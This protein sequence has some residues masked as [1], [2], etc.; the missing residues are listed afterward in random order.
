MPVT[1]QIPDSYPVPPFFLTAK[2]DEVAL[3]LELGASAVRHM[4]TK[5]IETVRR[6]THSDITDSYE[7]RIKKLQK[8]Y[9]SERD[10]LVAELERMG[11][12]GAK[13]REAARAE[14]RESMRELIEAKESQ[15]R[16]LE[17]TLQGL[18][19]KFDSLQTS[20]TRT[21]TSSK[22]KG[23][24]GEIIVEGMLKK[25]FDCDVE[26]V[27]KEAQTADIR[28]HR[29]A[30]DVYLWEVKN[31]TRMVTKEEVEKFRRDL[32]LHPEI[33]GGVLVS[34]R[35]GIVGKTRGGDIDVEFLEDGRAILFLSNLLSRDDAVFYLQTLRPFF[36]FVERTAHQ[37]RASCE[38]EKNSVK[39][40]SDSEEQLKQ[41]ALLVGNLIRNHSGNVVKHRNSLATHKKRT[42]AMFVEFQSYLMEAETQ[43]NTVLRLVIAEASDEA[44]LAVAAA[45]ELP[46]NV[47]VKS[48]LT[49][50]AEREREFVA[51]FLSETEL[52]EGSAITVKSLLDRAV[53]HKK[54]YNEKFVRGMRSV[55]FQEGVWPQGARTL[56]DVA[57]KVT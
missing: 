37:A 8:E 44:A 43:I 33:R 22:E 32:R 34:L 47:F 51:W 30:V 10:D 12:D 28:M 14:M 38:V 45:T 35:T 54:S 40:E 2:P 52:R 53:E 9:E 23:T 17:A 41:K 25:A 15:I 11:K 29:T 20:L 16:S 19:G 27:S 7:N 48:C 21:F 46:L 57:W 5:A 6:Q 24:L 49:D 4:E 55:V 1:L 39:K 31:Y 3:A 50:F 56:H 13:R 26:V 18:G 42:D 36:Q